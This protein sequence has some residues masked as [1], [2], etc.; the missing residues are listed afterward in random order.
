MQLWR[1]AP[2]F[3]STLWRLFDHVPITQIFGIGMQTK[4]ACR[5]LKLSA[6][7]A[8]NTCAMCGLLH[9]AVDVC[10]SDA[11]NHR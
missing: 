4:P 5:A 2:R 8:C 11:T 9:G 10:S 7:T 6:S 1:C 3:S